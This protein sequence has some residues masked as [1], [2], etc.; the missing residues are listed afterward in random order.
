MGRAASRRRVS[1]GRS[2]CRR[3][4]P[5]E[6][7]RPRQE[8]VLEPL[9]V[10]R[11]SSIRTRAGFLASVGGPRRSMSF[12]ERLREMSRFRTF[13]DSART[14]TWSACLLTWGC[15][16][17]PV[18]GTVTLFLL[19]R[20]SRPAT[21]PSIA[22]VIGTPARRSSDWSNPTERSSVTTA[23]LVL[24]TLSPFWYTRGCPATGQLHRLLEPEPRLV[25]PAD[26]RQQLLAERPRREHD[27]LEDA[28]LPV[29]ETLC[30]GGPVRGMSALSTVRETLPWTCV[31]LSSDRG[32]VA[33]Q[34]AGDLVVDL[35]AVDL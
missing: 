18:M 12:E 7:L 32:D 2:V 35:G 20:P 16:T 30:S 22:L 13:L 27:V 33:E 17:D 25:R 3:R 9:E 34:V 15:E 21:G 29:I 1:K 31:A 8:L 28:G 23:S 5:R 14:A 10:A 26:H 6:R 11:E 24:G 4:A 19:R